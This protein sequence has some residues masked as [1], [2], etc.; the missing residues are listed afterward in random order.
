MSPVSAY[1]F[2]RSRRF[3]YLNRSVP[4]YH[5]MHVLW[6]VH[7]LE[8][9]ITTCFCKHWNCKHIIIIPYYI[10][11]YFRRVCS[12]IW[13][14]DVGVRREDQF[15]LKLMKYECSETWY[16]IVIYWLYICDI[17]GHV[18]RKY[19]KFVA[20]EQFNKLLSSHINNFCI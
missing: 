10:I 18:L 2:R 4:T 15:L 16:F 12:F 14:E 20:V 1:I 3:V 8:R 6:L 7:L 17:S 11:N 13:R 19:S 9:P 5:I